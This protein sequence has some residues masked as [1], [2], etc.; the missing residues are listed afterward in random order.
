VRRGSGAGLLH[1]TDAALP[2]SSLERLAEQRWEARWY[3]FT[4]FFPLLG[5]PGFARRLR[6]GGCEM[7]QL[8]LE[9]ASPRVLQRLNKGIDPGRAAG[10]LRR[11]AD[12][13]IAVYLYI[14]FGV[15]GE[16]RRDAEQTLEFVARHAGEISFLHTSLLNLPLASPPEPDLRLSPYP[17]DHDLN[18]YC[19]FASDG[20]WER[21][22]ARL[23]LE[24][25][26]A[27]HP[28]VAPILRRTPRIFGANHAPFMKD[29][30]C[31]HETTS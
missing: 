30:Y 5:R 11:L 8:G 13:G 16:T 6:R 3:G 9:S 1:L 22:Q 20:G 31:T 24:R 28:Q 4:R 23:F 29:V 26:L 25:E 21:K 27:R 7:L 15:P 12:A 2:P 19:G 17:G 14:M 18:F 10:I